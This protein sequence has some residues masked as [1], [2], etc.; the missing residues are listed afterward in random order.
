MAST[1][2]RIQLDTLDRELAEVVSDS[3]GRK[4]AWPPSRKKWPSLSRP[5]FRALV[6]YL[7]KF[8]YVITFCSGVA[9]T[10]AWQSYGN[11]ARQIM[12]DSSPVLGWLA[13]P[14]AP[15][16][17]VVAEQATPA[18]PATPSVRQSVDQLSAKVQQMAGDIATLQATQQAIL[19]KVS[20]LP[21]KP[22]APTR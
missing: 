14:S 13:P 5:S 17:Q 16:V 1:L 20:I 22:P 10:L 18:E 12:A 8:R 3:L 4:N 7:I 9:T 21:G 6:R 15:L 11:V 19:R 2:H